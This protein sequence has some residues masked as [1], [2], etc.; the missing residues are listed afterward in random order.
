[1]NREELERSNAYIKHVLEELPQD[2]KLRAVFHEAAE[3]RR[4]MALVVKGFRPMY[5]KGHRFGFNYFMIDGYREHDGMHREVP[6]PTMCRL[7]GI[8]P[9]FVQ[10]AYSHFRNHERWPRLRPELDDEIDRA[11]KQMM[12]NLFPFPKIEWYRDGSTGGR[13][14]LYIIDRMSPFL[15]EEEIRGLYRP[16][17]AIWNAWNRNLRRKMREREQE[18]RHEERHALASPTH[19]QIRSKPL[20]EPTD[21]VFDVNQ[22]EAW[23]AQ[24]RQWISRQ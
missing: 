13:Y 15:S 20:L 11:A 8:D 16:G 4:D 1:M 3:G 7:A 14:L 10:D 23:L 19:P 2:N 9:C 18:R 22:F 5:Q 6:V 17:K 21:R 24:E 12:T